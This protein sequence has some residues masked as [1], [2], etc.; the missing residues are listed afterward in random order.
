MLEGTV[1]FDGLLPCYVAFGVI[2]VCCVVKDFVEY[3]VGAPGGAGADEFAVGCAQREEAG[4]VE[5]FVVGDEVEF[6]GVDDVEF[7]SADGFGV[8]G[9]CFDGAAVGEGD[10]GFLGFFVF[11]GEFFEEAVDVFDYEFGL[12]PAGTKDAYVAVW[13]GKRKVEEQGAYGVAFACLSC[14][15]CRD[16]LVFFKLP[17]ERG[18]V[19]GGVEA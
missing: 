7:G 18:L 4:V 12:S 5:F 17:D 9:V 14:P 2:L 10:G 13:V 8:V 3:A 15:P 19:G 1:G 11:G 16:E 6:V